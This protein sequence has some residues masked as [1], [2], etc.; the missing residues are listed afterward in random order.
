MILPKASIIPFQIHLFARTHDF[1]PGDTCDELRDGTSKMS[2]SD[3]SDMSRI[4]L[5]DN[6]D[7][8]RQKI[9]KAKSDSNGLNIEDLK[10]QPE[11]LT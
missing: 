9:K 2:K 10:L 7:L 4:N 3:P 6:E 11:A 8:I 1:G 5:M